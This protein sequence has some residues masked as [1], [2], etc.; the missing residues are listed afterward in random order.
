MKVVQI[1]CLAETGSTGRIVRQLAEALTQNG[2]ACGI[3]YSSGTSSWPDSFR[4]T[5]EPERKV[6]ALLSRVT[7]EQARFSRAGTRRL[8]CWLAA[9]KPDAVHLHNLHDNNICL[10]ALLHWLAQNDVPTVLTLHDCWYFTGRCTHYAPAGCAQWRTA[11]RRCPAG[12]DTLK[13][14]WFDRAA[15]MFAEKKRDLSAIP[16]LAAVGVSQWITDEARMGFLGQ[17]A[18]VRRIYNWVDETVFRPARTPAEAAAD[19]AALPAALRDKHVYLCA[20]ARWS[21]AKGLALLEPLARCLAPDEALAVAGLLPEGV[22]LPPNAAA[23]GLVQDDAQLARLYRAADVFCG[24][25]LWETFGLVTAEALACGTPAVVR[26]ST[27]NPELIGPGCGE[28]VEA[29]APP[30]AFYAAVRRVR[31][32]GK[33]ALGP[34]CTAFAQ[35]HFN[36]ETN[37]AAY[38]ALYHALAEGREQHAQTFL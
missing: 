34:Q 6:H 20:A 13:S 35:T 8:L 24:L 27:A 26:A 22:R 14:W 37:T 25:S 2:D 23:L 29:E 7:G 30:A 5:N 31:A 28:V 1:N 17:C 9:E 32:A 15:P 10:P 33:A 36:K 16:R 38:V 3:A 4:Y 12:A 19:R 18:E 21:E 11:C